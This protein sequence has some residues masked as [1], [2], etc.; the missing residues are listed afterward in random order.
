MQSHRTSK[1]AAVEAGTTA[2]LFSSQKRRFD[3][4]KTV[5][6]TLKTNE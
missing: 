4:S 6:A 3:S 2:L 1:M 5:K